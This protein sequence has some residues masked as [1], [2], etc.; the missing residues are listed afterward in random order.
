MLL[1]CKLLYTCALHVCQQL[2][3]EFVTLHVYLL[4]DET[5]KD[6]YQNHSLDTH[7]LLA[8]ALHMNCTRIACIVHKTHIHMHS[9]N[10]H[11]ACKILIHAFSMSI[12]LTS[13]SPG[14]CSAPGTC[15]NAIESPYCLTAGAPDS[16][17][18]P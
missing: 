8:C 15:S 7:T 3:H 6:Q 13:Q 11:N 17:G 16:V 18:R 9:N 12:Q 14:K 5:K 10:L 4:I 2:A 1:A